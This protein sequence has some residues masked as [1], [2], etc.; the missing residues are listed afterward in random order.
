MAATAQGTGE[1]G[2]WAFLNRWQSEVRVSSP[3]ETAAPAP[4][5]HR[6]GRLILCIIDKTTAPSLSSRPYLEFH[7]SSSSATI[8]PGFS[9][10]IRRITHK[11]VPRLWANSA[12]K[13]ELNALPE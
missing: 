3:R 7:M 11:V 6:V 12:Q 2:P 4:P 8:C 10:T 1:Q 5:G 9:L 13:T